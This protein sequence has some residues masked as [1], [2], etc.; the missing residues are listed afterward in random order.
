METSYYS[1][2]FQATTTHSPFPSRTMSMTR[3]RK[4]EREREDLCARSFRDGTRFLLD[5]DQ[6]GTNDLFD[7]PK[8]VDDL[9]LAEIL[10]NFRGEFLTEWWS[11]ANVIGYLFFI[12]MLMTRHVRPRIFIYFYGNVVHRYLSSDLEERIPP[13]IRGVFVPQRSYK[14]AHRLSVK[15]KIKYWKEKLV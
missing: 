10:I 4:K 1:V 3:R 9:D 13:F 8:D 11:S 7:V 14:I 2:N 6:E 12:D 5:H 15:E